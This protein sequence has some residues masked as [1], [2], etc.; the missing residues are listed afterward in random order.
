RIPNFDP[1]D[2]SETVVVNLDSLTTNELTLVADY[3]GE[4][5][6]VRFALDNNTNFHTDNSAPFTFTEN[7]AAWNPGPGEYAISATP[8]S[9]TGASGN[10]GPG[11]G[12]RLR[13][14]QALLAVE[15]TDSALYANL[16][17]GEG[18]QTILPIN[19]T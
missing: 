2:D 13:L 18:A 5:A 10:R 16:S 8:F 12:L 19:N 14:E 6:S 7:S 4:V 9:G 17:S 15:P 1:L 11:I 3:E